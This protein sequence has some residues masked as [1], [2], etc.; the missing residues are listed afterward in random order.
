MENCGSSLF[1]SILWIKIILGHEET[2]VAT[3]GAI[4]KN[5]CAICINQI[6]KTIFLY[7]YDTKTM[8]II[9][10]HGVNIL[11]KAGRDRTSTYPPPNYLRNFS[12][13][14]SS[15]FPFSYFSKRQSTRGKRTQILLPL[16]L[17]LPTFSNGW[18]HWEALK[19]PLF[20]SFFSSF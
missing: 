16:V 3:T 1:F 17:F 15:H 20:S 13:L 12:A 4:M 5:L 11:W 9:Y 7:T 6:N 2:P 14:K 19:T 10:E 8:W 18:Q